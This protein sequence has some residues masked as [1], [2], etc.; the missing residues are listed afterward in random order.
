MLA[1]ADKT[2]DRKSYRSPSPEGYNLSVGDDLHLMI[3]D[4]GP[5]YEEE[6]LAE[7]SLAKHSARR[8]ELMF[9]GVMIDEFRVMSQ[10]S[11]VMID[12]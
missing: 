9:D 6:R 2:L 5:L 11:R 10:G 7:R 8:G 4:F 3:V 1:P 12:H